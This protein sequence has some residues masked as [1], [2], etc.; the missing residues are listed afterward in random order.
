MSC[1]HLSSYRTLPLFEALGSGLDVLVVSTDFAEV[2][3]ICHRAI[4]FSRGA[5][6]AELAG[7]GLLFPRLGE[8][9]GHRGAD[10]AAAVKPTFGWFADC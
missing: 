1:G 6:V 5:G 3:T 10:H 2:A 4:V 9:P 8:L 7:N